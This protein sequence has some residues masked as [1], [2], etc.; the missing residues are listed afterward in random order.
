MAR[1]MTP[2]LLGT[3]AHIVCGRCAPVAFSLAIP[4]MSLR[5]RPHSRILLVKT[6]PWVNASPKFHVTLILAAK[7]KA[8]IGST[9]ILCLIHPFHALCSFFK[10]IDVL[11][12]IWTLES[13]HRILFYGGV[14]IIFPDF[15]PHLN[16]LIVSVFLD[17]RQLKWISFYT[18]CVPLWKELSRMLF[19]PWISEVRQGI[20][21]IWILH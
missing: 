18:H 11:L 10:E 15:S 16:S 3:R 8:A 7:P 12:R 5:V 13:P 6:K 20:R 1:R 17:K 14:L 2:E 4:N 9:G 19:D 21:N